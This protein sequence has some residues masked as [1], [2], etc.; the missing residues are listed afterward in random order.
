MEVKEIPKKTVSFFSAILI[1]V[2][3]ITIIALQ[4][5]SADSLITLPSGKNSDSSQSQNKTGILQKVSIV[6]VSQQPDGRIIRLS[7]QA[8]LTTGSAI[9]YEIWPANISMRKKTASEIMGSAGK[10]T[11]YQQNGSAVWSVTMDMGSWDRGGYVMNA[12]PEQNDPRYGDRKIFFIPINDTISNG[13][14]TSSGNGEILLTSL[15]PSETSGYLVSVTPHLTPDRSDVL[16]P[17][18]Q[19]LMDAEVIINE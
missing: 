14:G 10:T 8:N 15:S 19:K 4:S 7:G 6:S 12:W 17:Q 18:D 11:C 16:Q 1:F 2:V 5:Y 3:I 13:A 9:L